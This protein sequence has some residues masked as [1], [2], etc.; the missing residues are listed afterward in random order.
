MQDGTTISS[1][2]NQ[3]YMHVEDSKYIKYEYTAGSSYL[4]VTV[5]DAL[6]F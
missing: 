6:L 1:L 3:G 2:L 5:A 4:K